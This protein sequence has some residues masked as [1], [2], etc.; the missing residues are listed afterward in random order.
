MSE[1]WKV[2]ELV[3]DMSIPP[4]QKRK[5]TKNYSLSVAFEHPVL[6]GSILTVELW[7]KRKWWHLWRRPCKNVTAVVDTLGNTFIKV[8]KSRWE[9]WNCVGGPLIVITAT[10]NSAAPVTMEIGE[11]IDSKK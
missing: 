2:K 11:R 6:S 5:S 4:M 1:D 8:A 9:C 3:N 10:F 7:E